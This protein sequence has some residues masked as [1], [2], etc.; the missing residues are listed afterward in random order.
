MARSVGLT[1]FAAA[2]A[3]FACDKSP[4]AEPDADLPADLPPLAPLAPPSPSPSLTPDAGALAAGPI[5]DSGRAP[6]GKSGVA[7]ADARAP[8][9]AALKVRDGGAAVACGDAP[10]DPCPLQAWMRAHSGP[11]VMSGDLD[12]IALDFDAIATFA[13]GSPDAGTLGFDNWVSIAKDG[14]DAA[15]AA[16]MVGIRGACRGCHQQYKD[17]YRAALRARA[18]P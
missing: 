17:R 4:F 13:P 15:R 14:A 12:A 9:A 2:A 16:S 18:L 3:M 10:L 6:D 11:D 8:D 1:A 7:K 5:G